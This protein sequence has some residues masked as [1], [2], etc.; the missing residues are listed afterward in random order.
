MECKVY[1]RSEI[2]HLA[3]PNDPYIVISVNN[4]AQDYARVPVNQWCAGVLRLKFDHVQHTVHGPPQFKPFTEIQ[5]REVWA[6][7]EAY[8]NVKFCL[9]HCN[10]GRNRSPAIAAAITGH[11]GGDVRPY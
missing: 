1:S 9:V 4:T 3:P 2:E 6:F 5:A 10:H 11:F 7:V 8:K